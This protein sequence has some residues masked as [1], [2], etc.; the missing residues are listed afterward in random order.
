MHCRNVNNICN[1]FRIKKLFLCL[2]IQLLLY[3]YR[4][5][6]HLG[7]SNFYVGKVRFVSEGESSI[8]MGVAST[9]REDKRPRRYYIAEN[10]GS[11]NM[12]SSH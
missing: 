8:T 6:F 5:A 4:T 1:F 12:S 2:Q 10:S 9:I 3:I 11:P 7:K